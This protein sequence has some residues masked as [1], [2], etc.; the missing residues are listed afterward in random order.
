MSE[1]EERFFK[2][3]KIRPIEIGNIFK[4]YPKIEG[5]I[6]LQLICAYNK[7]QPCVD[8]LIYPYDYENIKEDVLKTLLNEDTYIDREKLEI[9]VS[10][11]F[12]GFV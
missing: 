5:D 2:E 11:I 7:L 1:V 12:G 3:F 10:Y 9:E 6:L 8:Y 4:V